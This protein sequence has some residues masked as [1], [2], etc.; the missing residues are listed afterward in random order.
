MMICE[1]FDS[2]DWHF[3]QKADTKVDEGEI[4]LDI[5]A[6]EGCFRFQWLIDA[7]KLS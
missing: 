2:R 4:L 1:T 7:P 5:G 3:Y 6:A